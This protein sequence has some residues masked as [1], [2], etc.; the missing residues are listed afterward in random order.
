MRE[1]FK[2]P[3]D[4]LIADDPQM[5]DFLVHCACQWLAFCQEAR[6]I[7]AQCKQGKH[8]KTDGRFGMST[9]KELWR[10]SPNTE[11]RKLEAWR[12]QGRG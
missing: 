8:S 2:L 7:E 9:Q 1:H 6:E 5:S 12:M 11:F 10:P 3:A 4:P